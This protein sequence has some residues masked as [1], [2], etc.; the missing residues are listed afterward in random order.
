MQISNLRFFDYSQKSHRCVRLCVL[1]LLA[2][3]DLLYLLCVLS[4]DPFFLLHPGHRARNSEDFDHLFGQK[5]F[6]VVVL[7]YVVCVSRLLCVWLSS[8][9]PNW[10]VVLLACVCLCLQKLVPS[11]SKIKKSALDGTC[12]LDIRARSH[13]LRCGHCCAGG[14]LSRMLRSSI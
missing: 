8:V 7:V 10:C 1:S 2:D 9:A 14:G 6:V 3:L 12:L 11:S 13:C 5:V 4:F